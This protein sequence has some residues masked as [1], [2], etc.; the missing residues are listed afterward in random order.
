MFCEER[1]IQVKAG[2]QLM[3]E[4]L[5]DDKGGI[6]NMSMRLLW[7]GLK[8]DSQELIAAKASLYFLIC[9]DVSKLTHVSSS[10]ET[11]HSLN[12]FLPGIWSV[13]NELIYLTNTRPNLKWVS[14]AEKY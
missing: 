7:V 5:L 12:C 1:K 4:H 3:A 13:C 8:G 9:P 10:Q 2:I 6:W 11:L 14:R